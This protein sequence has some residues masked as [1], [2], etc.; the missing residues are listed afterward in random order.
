VDEFLSDIWAWLGRNHEVVTTPAIVVAVLVFTW[1]LTRISGAVVR[2][3][4]RR[5]AT[6]SLLATDAS[7]GVWRTRVRR[8]ALETAEI[9]EQR[10]AQR[11]DAAAKMVNHLISLVFWIVAII[12]LFN[13]F[14]VNAAFYLS[15]AG[16]IGAALAIGGQHKV[17]DYL[18][19]LSVLFEDRYGVG[20]VIE[21]NGG[22]D[23]PIRA[24]VDNVGLFSTRL[25]DATSTLHFANAA[26]G[27]VRN[28][29]QEPAAATLRV[30]TAGLDPVDVVETMKGMAGT[31]D[32]TRVVFLGD[33]D[34]HHP[35][36]GEVEI[37]VHTLRP[38]DPEAAETLIRRV[39]EQLE[40]RAERS[41][42]QPP[43]T[44]RDAVS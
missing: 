29:S 36:T 32:L 17:N 35:T 4:V 7:S 25:R 44:E 14:D 6:R 20:D 27:E 39:E 43:A 9:S 21:F 38:L 23:E 12:A 40:E 8:A 34:T 18:S 22:R 11:I 41:P 10:R 24:V 42:R 37:D 16:F 33:L 3:V 19:G 28:L 31:S 1:V 13:I 26:L 2:R 30:R 15:S 5:L